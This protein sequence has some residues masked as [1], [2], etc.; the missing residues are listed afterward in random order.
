MSDANP[1]QHDAAILVLRDRERE[2]F[3]EMQNHQR[4]LEIATARR[5]E[6]LDLIAT[7]SR[8]PRPRRARPTTEALPEPANDPA[9]SVFGAPSG[10]IVEA[11]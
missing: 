11:A 10:A 1:T 3:A 2:L 6:L 7:L 4:S 8:K 5:E 9:P